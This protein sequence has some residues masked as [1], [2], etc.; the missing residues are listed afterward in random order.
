MKSILGSRNKDLIYIILSPISGFLLLGVYLILL[1]VFSLPVYPTVIILIVVYSIFF[2][3]NHYFSTYYRVFLDKDYYKSNKQW[4]IPALVFVTIV[5]M[6]AFFFLSYGSINQKGYYFFVFLRKF[7]LTLGFYHL[8][9]Q[10]WGFMAMYKKQANEK[11]TKINWDQLALMSGSFIPFTMLNVVKDKGYIWFPDSEKYIFDSVYITPH[12]IDWWHQMAQ[13]NFLFFIIL[14]AI[15]LFYKRFQFRIPAR[16]MSLF[17]L[18]TGC[19]IESM[20]RWD[21]SII[22]TSILWVVVAI[23]VVSIYQ[24]IRYQIKEGKLNARKWAVF[25][26]TLVLYFCIIL[27]PI[28]GDIFI[29][30][31][32]ITLPHNIQYL[33]FVPTFSNHQYAQDNKDHGWA[34]KLGKHAVALFFIGALFSVF[35]EF[36]RTGTMFVLPDS[37]QQTKIIISVFFVVLIL[38]HYY[39]DAV[40][41][42]FSKNK[43]LQKARDTKE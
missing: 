4:M 33:S 11:V 2:D 31:A 8:V 27:Y 18:F 16:N 19:L 15:A 40:I 6:G 36:G 22:L 17:C 25:V 37:M 5:P 13:L 41:W 23:F 29:I 1:N 32:A 43:D 28:H 39:L 42:K 26:S 20:M 38:H 7:V 10:N 9:K 3:V 34:K 30:V 21:A 24:S 35:F 14:G 12:L